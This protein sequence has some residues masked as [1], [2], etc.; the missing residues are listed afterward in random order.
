[1]VRLKADTSCTPAP[2]GMDGPPEG[3][4]YVRSRARRHWMVRL[5]ADTSCTPAP[6][7]M[8]GPPEGGHYVR[9]RARRRNSRTVKVRAAFGGM[10]AAARAFTAGDDGCGAGLHGP[11]RREHDVRSVRLQPDHLLSR[12]Q[13]S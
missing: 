7:G 13:Q 9:S 10:T 4:H 3:G 2:E 8:D 12:A 6:E 1:M 11:R 5:T